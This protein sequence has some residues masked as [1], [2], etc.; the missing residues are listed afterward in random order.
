MVERRVDQ[1]QYEWLKE[2]VRTIDLLNIDEE[3]CQISELV[4]MAS[5]LAAKASDEE[6]RLHHEYDIVCAEF[7][8]NMREQNDRISEARI[9]SEKHLC[10][11]VR[12]AREAHN[13]AQYDE[14]LA[15]GVATALKSKDKHIQNGGQLVISNYLTRDYITAKRVRELQQGRYNGSSTD[16]NS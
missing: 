2:H 6:R 12:A 5:I 1:K 4:S 11:E 3:L 13:K 7:A 9:N 16:S 8:K 10:P 15:K 14:D